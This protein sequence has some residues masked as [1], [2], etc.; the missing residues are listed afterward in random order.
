MVISPVVPGLRRDGWTNFRYGHNIV[1]NGDA[2]ALY[3]VGVPSGRICGLQQLV[4]ECV[5]GFD[6]CELVIETNP[7]KTRWCQNASEGD[8]A[9]SGVDSG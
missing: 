6:F 9:V 5:L 2:D 7:S 4:D 1:S 8:S 3:L